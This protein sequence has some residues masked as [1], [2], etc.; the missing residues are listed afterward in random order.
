MFSKETLEN[1]VGRIRGEVAC[2]LPVRSNEDAMRVNQI[3]E[4][5]LA[6]K[7]VLKREDEIDLTNEDEV[8]IALRE[9]AVNIGVDDVARTVEIAVEEIGKA[10]E[11]NNAPS[12]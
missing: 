5:S 3:R 2:L 4:A 7:Y 8:R 1:A 10:F 12:M 9:E 6:I 11:V